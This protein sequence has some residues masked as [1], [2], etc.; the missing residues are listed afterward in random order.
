[1]CGTLQ[2]HAAEAER[3]I[4]PLFDVRID[5]DFPEPEASFREIM[6]LVEENYYTDQIDEKTLWWAA[7]KGM[8]R[9][10]SPDEN[11]GL[12]AIWLP[13]QYDQVDQKL[14]G[15][16]ESIGIKSSYNPGDGSLTVTEVLE[17]GPSETLLQPYDRIVRIDGKPIRSLP[18]DEVDDMLKGDPGT[19]VA[20]KVVR[21]VAVFDLE[22][23][24]ASVKLENMQ[25]DVLP[26]EVGYIA[27]RS[28]SKGISD[29][30]RNELEMMEAGELTAIILDLRGNTGGILQEGL[31]TAELFIPK[32]ES[33]LRVVS[34]GSKVSNYVSAQELPF[35]LDVVVLVNHRTASA[36]EIVAAALHD[37]TGATLVGT[38][39]FGKG[40]MERI[41]T[42][43][44]DYRVKFTIGAMYSPKGKTWQ[45]TGLVPD[46]EVDMDPA[47][48]AKTLD[49]DMRLRLLNDPQLRAAHQ[50]LR[51]DR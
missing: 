12:A 10:L 21:D 46:V 48:L 28:F 13:E 27:L 51:K 4:K 5:H 39:T 16:R 50:F 31:K 14:N 47:K 3:T 26:G 1:V 18:L 9:Q 44:N 45:K 43:K 37:M 49:L 24:R 6:A 36:G 29:D 34:H 17:G 20:L 11:P 33:L 42:L 22:I 23:P 30:L 15:V 35:R 8:L 41:F 32:G 7:V 25:H 38:R 19:V 2:L 40:T